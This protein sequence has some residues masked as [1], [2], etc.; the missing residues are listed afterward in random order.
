MYKGPLKGVALFRFNKM[1]G[2]NA[3]KS[4]FF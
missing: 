2:F 4:E 1:T 3:D